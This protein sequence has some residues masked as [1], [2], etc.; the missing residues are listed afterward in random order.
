MV[1]FLAGYVPPKQLE[2]VGL[3]DNDGASAGDTE[4][5][6]Y[7]GR[8]QH[9]KWIGWYKLFHHYTETLGIKLHFMNWGWQ[10][11]GDQTEEAVDPL[12][13]KIMAKDANVRKID[14]TSFQLYLHLLKD[15]ELSGAKLLEVSSGKGGGLAC[16][17]AS[18]GVETAIGVDLCT[19]NVEYCEETY[20]TA[21][22]DAGSFATKMGLDAACTGAL[23]FRQGDAMKLA[24]TFGAETG[25]E[26]DYVLNV[27]ASH[28]YPS[29]PDFFDSVWEVLKPGGTLLFVDFMSGENLGKCRK[30]LGNKAKWNLDIDESVTANVIQ[31]MEHS[32]QSKEN[33]IKDS[34][35]WW[36]SYQPFKY[37]ITKFAATKGSHKCV[38]GEQSRARVPPP[39][40]FNFSFLSMFPFN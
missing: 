10:P 34:T 1:Y 13:H 20:G 9:L 6:T 2:F 19:G 30:S 40:C 3:L 35:P 8:F 18:T 25:M 29:R 16:I 32:S 36:T 4:R 12:C 23:S 24:D 39:P 14:E 33:V 27:E 7:K 31:A 15:V 17:A 11:L 22:G 21:S 26:F 38:G 28:C 37:V 5:D